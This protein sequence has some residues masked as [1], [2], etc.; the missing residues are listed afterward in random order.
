MRKLFQ[1]FSVTYGKYL[2]TLTNVYPERNFSS[3]L[4]T[5][6]VLIELCPMVPFVAKVLHGVTESTFA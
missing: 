2:R 3:N 1:N 5:I 6:D 4:G